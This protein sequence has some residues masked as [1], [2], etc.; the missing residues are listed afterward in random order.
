[1]SRLLWIALVVAILVG[2]LSVA[3]ITGGTWAKVSKLRLSMG[4]LRGLAIVILA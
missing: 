1:M 4:F 2:A 3:Y